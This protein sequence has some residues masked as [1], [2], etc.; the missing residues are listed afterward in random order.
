MSFKGSFNWAR[1]KYKL[2]CKEESQ[3]R[4]KGRDNTKKN[5]HILYIL[6]EY[7]YSFMNIYAYIFI[8]THR[9]REPIYL[10]KCPLDTGYIFPLISSKPFTI[11]PP[12]ENYQ[13]N[14]N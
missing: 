2:K 8:I 4:K 7:I 3:M 5:I 11:V 12:L 14:F 6:H 10:Y 9:E 1:R 13:L